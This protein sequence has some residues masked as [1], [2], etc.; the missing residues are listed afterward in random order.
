MPRTAI[1]MTISSR[2]REGGC[3]QII[4]LCILAALRT[5]FTSHMLLA[6]LDVIR[7]VAHVCK[8]HRYHP[9]FL[10][11]C[12]SCLRS[13]SNWNVHIIKKH[14][15]RGCSPQVHEDSSIEAYI[16]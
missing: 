10:F 11:Y 16:T 14:V 12:S 3:M 6:I 15:S 4:T 8:I 9:N 13:N 1:G 7:M 5:K 2:S